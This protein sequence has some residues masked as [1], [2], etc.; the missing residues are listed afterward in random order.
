MWSECAVSAGQKAGTISDSRDSQ[1]MC[2]IGVASGS[3]YW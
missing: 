2:V 1:C 3:G